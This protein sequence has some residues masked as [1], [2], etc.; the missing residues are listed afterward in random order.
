LIALQY[1]LLPTQNCCKYCSNLE[2]VAC[3]HA[4]EKKEID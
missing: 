3:V 1:V 2:H 4:T